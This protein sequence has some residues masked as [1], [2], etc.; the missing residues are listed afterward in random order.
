MS[1]AFTGFSVV[2]PTHGRPRALGRCLAALAAQSFPAGAYEVIVVNDGGPWP[3]APP[4]PA[5]ACAIRVL[6][7]PRNSGPGPARNH[8]ARLARFSHLAFTDDDC[9]PDPD[10]LARLAVVCRHDPEAMLGGRTLNRLR[11]DPFAEA[12]QVVVTAAYRWHNAGPGPARF[13]AANNMV[14]PHASF[15][16]LGG[17]GGAFRTAE[18]RDLCDRW[19]EA[20]GRIVEVKGAWI[21]HAHALHPASFWRQHRHYGR[22]A[23]QLHQA[24]SRRSGQRFRPD[25]RFFGTLLLEPFRQHSPQRA[26]PLAP[27]CLLSQLASLHGFTEAG[28]AAWRGS[29]PGDG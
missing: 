11:R 12:S 27:L 15:I 7:Q 21:R 6:H 10:W 18:D 13:L 23:F 3:D 22:G 1:P 17:F 29:R 5:T 8:G 19:L 20:G 16:R 25:P 9:E 2:V 14:C 28:L 26:L 4:I 24:R